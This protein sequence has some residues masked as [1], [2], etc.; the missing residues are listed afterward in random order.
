MITPTLYLGAAVDPLLLEVGVD[1]TDDD[2]APYELLA[3]S[4]PVVP[5]GPG[6]ECAFPLL[7]LS[8]IH[9]SGDV[10][11]WITPVVDGVDGETQRL[12]LIGV[13][14]SKGERVTTEID[15]SIP[16]VVD[17]VEQSRYHLRGAQF[18]AR[19]ETKYADAEVGAAS[20]AAKT[21][22]ES[23]ELEYEVLRESRPALG[24]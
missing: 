8:T 13:P 4:V 12:D 21:V 17:G 23:V 19:V 10:S 16:Y 3:Q 22:V 6:G 1:Y 15:L 2:D 14:N 7:Y 9:Y 11:L 5:A 20:T 24:S 18:Q